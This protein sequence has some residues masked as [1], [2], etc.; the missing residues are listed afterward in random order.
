M[1]T[2]GSS[3]LSRGHERLDDPPVEGHGRQ[4]RWVNQLRWHTAQLLE[5]LHVLGHGHLGRQPLHAR[6]AVE[7][8]D[9]LRA[10]EHVLGVLGLG[11][12]AAVAEHDHV[13][14]HR[15]RRVAHRLDLDHAVV[16]RLRRLG[17]DRALGGQPHVRDEHVGAGLGHRDGLVGVEHV[18][19]GQQAHRGGRADHV[20]LEAE[21]HAG[22]FEVGPERAVDQADG[23][24]VLH[25]REAG[26]ARPGAGRRPSAGTGRSR[27]R[28]RAP[29]C[30]ARPAAPRRPSP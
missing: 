10:V 3:V 19:R 12:R 23:R 24:E 20:D 5:S 7:A 26:V 25:A 17:A 14:P 1:L 13:G 21:A 16:E 9:A 30:R 18:R 8:G 11:D 6:G 4:G 29:A 28:R 22:L 15:D 2:A 27:R